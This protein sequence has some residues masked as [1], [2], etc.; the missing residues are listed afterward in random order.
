MKV[1]SRTQFS[2]L[3][4]S[5][6]MR[7]IWLNLPTGALHIG[8]FANV[9]VL[10]LPDSG[11]F[12]DKLWGENIIKGFLITRSPVIYYLHYLDK[13]FESLTC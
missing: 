11:N 12:S 6:I 4:H 5:Q 8:K 10:Q 13:Y 3:V 9:M 2:L 7:P 1:M